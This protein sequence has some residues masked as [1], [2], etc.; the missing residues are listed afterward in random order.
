MTPLTDASEV[1]LRSV[2]QLLRSYSRMSF[3]GVWLR[4]REYSRLAHWAIA[5]FAG[6]GTFAAP[7]DREIIV[8]FRAGAGA[9]QVAEARQDARLV[10]KRQVRTRAMLRNG[11]SGLELA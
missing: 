1:E 8:R 11:R 6:V 5:F 10:S 2:C 4:M 7:G 9:A 3:P